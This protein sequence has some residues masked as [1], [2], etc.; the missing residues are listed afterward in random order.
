[1]DKQK[2]I[3]KMRKLIEEEKKKAIVEISDEEFIQVQHTLNSLRDL[4]TQE[5]LMK[6]VIEDEKAEESV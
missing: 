1:M 6:N 5:L 4:K 3:E 2:Y